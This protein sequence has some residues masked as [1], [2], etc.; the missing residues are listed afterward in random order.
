MSLFTDV[1]ISRARLNVF[2]IADTSPWIRN[3]CRSIAQKYNA[4]FLTTSK[5]M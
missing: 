2:L 3:T 4:S 1:Y 5:T